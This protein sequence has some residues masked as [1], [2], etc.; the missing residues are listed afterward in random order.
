MNN[1]LQTTIRKVG[2]RNESYIFLILLA[3]SLL[4]EIR[5]G[6]FFSSNNLVDIASAMVVPG[7]FAIGATMVLVSG[8]IDVSFPALASLSVYATTKYLLDIG[9]QGGVWLPILMAL[10]I[11]AV[12]GAFNG[13]FIGYFRLPA[14]IVTLGSASVFKGLMQGALNSKQLTLIPQGMRDFGTSTLFIAE[15]PVSGLTSRMPTA[16][17]A[18]L[19]VLF[20]VS[21]MFRYTMFGRGIYSLGGNEVSARRAGYNVIRTKFIMYIMVGMIASLAGVMRVCM[22]QQAH[23]TNM[24]GMEINIIAGVVLGGASITGGRGTL[25]GCM[26]G[27]LLIVIVQNS[28]ILLGIPTSW[29]SIFTGALIIA[30]T[31]ISAYQMI[32]SNRVRSRKMMKKGAA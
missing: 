13:L 4:I 23:P 9:Y 26:L 20:L 5:S 16:F 10:G 29:K 25:L 27:T 3:L 11:G 1:R 14:L 24:L 28:M 21:F 32:H 17:L 12:L 31:G 19:I 2:Q 8:G 18:F 7:L 6:Q 15:N 22:M 30:G